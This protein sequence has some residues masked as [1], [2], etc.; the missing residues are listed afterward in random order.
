MTYD[1]LR[2]EVYGPTRATQLRSLT[3][4]ALMAGVVIVIMAGIAFAYD[5][6]N[7]GLY[8]GL[9]GLILVGFSLAT[10]H[11]LRQRRFLAK[12]LSAMTATLVV[13]MGIVVLGLFGVVLI[14]VGIWMLVQALRRD[15]ELV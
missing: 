11:H 14:G 6:L 3:Y 12:V 8:L 9:P 15:D 4:G 1:P 10:L 5:D 7:V 2:R 13:V